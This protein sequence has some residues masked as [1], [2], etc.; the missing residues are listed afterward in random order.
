MPE[1]AKNT[2][3]SRRRASEKRKRDA[4]VDI[5]SDNSIREEPAV[6][7][8]LESGRQDGQ[9]ARGEFND[10]AQAMA[11]GTAAEADGDEEESLIRILKQ[12]GISVE[13]IAEEDI[14]QE[15]D[16]ETLAADHDE[17]EAASGREEERLELEERADTW[18]RD[19]GATGDPVRQYLQEIGRVKLLTLEEEISLARRIEEGEAARARLD[20]EASSLGDRERRKLQ[21]VVEDGDLARQNLIEANLRLVVS[22]AKKYRGRGMGF[23]D[24]VQE[25]NQGL[26]RAVEKF[27]YRRG[28]KFSTYATWWIR[29]AV[30]RAIAD[31][32]RTIRIPVHMVETINKLTRIRRT[33]HQ[34]HGEEPSWQ[35]IADAMGPEWNAEK[36]EEAFRLAREPFSLETPIGDEEDSF[37]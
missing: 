32:A 13:E 4:E 6:R 21:R 15:D 36:V 25:G 12:E 28:Y 29:Q 33:L 18:T 35:D 31:Q 20:E 24:L 8:L 10:A 2:V 3:Q 22:I 37:Y 34:E 1:E 16:E 9:V 27:D 26:I 30:N 11:D 19:T 5:R 23:L 14:E 7:K 17:D